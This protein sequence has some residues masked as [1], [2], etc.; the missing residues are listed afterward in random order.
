MLIEAPIVPTLLRLAAPNVLN[1][2]AF[3]GLITFD[4]F[5]LQRRLLREFFRVGLPGMSNVGIDNLMVVA[6]TAL[7]ARMGREAA[8]AY[9]MGARL[10]YI[11]IPLGFGIG[12]GIVTTVGTNWGAKQHRRAFAVAWAGWQ[13]RRVA[14]P[15]SSS[16]SAPRCGWDSSRPN[17]K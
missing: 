4:G 11:I 6:M 3:V 2:V 7:A 17:P 8:I 1:L 14:G 9:A 5:R 12:T 16:R 13:Q 10:E 15:A